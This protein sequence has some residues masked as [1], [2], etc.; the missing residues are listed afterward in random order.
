[1]ATKKASTKKTAK[2]AS[3]KAVGPTIPPPP[4]PLKCIRDC[5]DQYMSCLKKGV[6]PDLCWKR[7]TRCVQGCFKK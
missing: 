3:K 5:Y 1:M 4:I 2:K 7:Y 6:D